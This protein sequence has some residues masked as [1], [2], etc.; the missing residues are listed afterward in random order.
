MARTAGKSPA[1]AGLFRLR[2]TPV[3][4][5]V[6]PDLRADNNM[7]IDGLRFVQITLLLLA[8]AAT[9]PVR[10]QAQ[11]TPFEP[12]DGI[13]KLE[14]M[15][16]DVGEVE[17]DERAVIAMRTDAQQ[18]RKLGRSCAETYTPQIERLQ[19]ELKVL[20]EPDPNEEID[21]YERRRQT[22]EELARVQ[23]SQS[24]CQLLEIRAQDFIA[25]ADRALNS[26]AS[27]KMWSRGPGLLIEFRVAVDSLKALPSFTQLHANLEG[28]FDVT[29][30]SMLIVAILLAG[31]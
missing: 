4:T 3:Y 10:A 26:M 16:R 9:S 11:E 12:A 5:G 17:L 28:R 18:L 1:D 13:A 8:V 22:S 21:I 7:R 24:N 19:A 30:I 15:S 2:G 20:G 25:L 27:K 29:P 14:K 6:G 31:L 23:S